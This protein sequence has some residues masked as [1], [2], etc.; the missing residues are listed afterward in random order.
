MADVTFLSA[1]VVAQLF[2]KLHADCVVAPLSPAP[3]YFF[4]FFSEPGRGSDH[5]ADGRTDGRNVGAPRPI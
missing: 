3:S 5:V 2:A 4:P 1:S